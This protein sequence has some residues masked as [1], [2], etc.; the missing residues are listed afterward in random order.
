MKNI[1][2]L[3]INSKKIKKESID[4]IIKSSISMYGGKGSDI[5]VICDMSLLDNVVEVFGRDS[6]IT[7]YD[8]SHF[9]LVI[10]KDIDGF[11]YYVLRNIEHIDI[12]KPK[13]LKLEIEKILKDYLR[14]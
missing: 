5:E 14:R 9:K 7:K 8:N 4:E 3:D 1:K 13:E 11:K 12:I 6:K 2:V 10:N